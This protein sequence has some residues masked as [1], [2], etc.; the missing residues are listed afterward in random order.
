MT[1]KGPSSWSLQASTAWP[2]PQGLVRQGVQFL[3]SVAQLDAEAGA[4][5]LD[6]VADGLPERL[7]DVVAD[8]EHDL[9]KARFD[10]VVDGIIHDDLAVGAHGRQLLDAAAKP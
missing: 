4:D 2:V 8:D 1:A 10:G 6:A 9:V 5:A 3:K 7:F